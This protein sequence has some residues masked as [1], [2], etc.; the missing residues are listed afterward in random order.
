MPLEVSVYELYDLLWHRKRLNPSLWHH[1]AKRCGPHRCLSCL[2]L[3]HRQLQTLVRTVREDS[4]ADAR[5]HVVWYRTRAAHSS[6]IHHV[7]ISHQQLSHCSNAVR[8]LDSTV[9]RCLVF[10]LENEVEA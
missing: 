4:V 1:Q 10:P 2:S 5:L 3:T 9:Q 8:F 6:V 7:V